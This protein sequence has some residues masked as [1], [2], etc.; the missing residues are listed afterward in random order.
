MKPRLTD[1]IYLGYT[2]EDISG[3]CHSYDLVSLC[4]LKLD[5]MS[6]ALNGYY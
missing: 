6:L 3:V 2:L 4:M 5:E 1:G